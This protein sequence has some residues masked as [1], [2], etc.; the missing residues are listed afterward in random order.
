[1]IGT[2]KV[3][4]IP[5]VDLDQGWGPVLNTNSAFTTDLTDWRAL[6]GAAWVWVTGGYAAPGQVS[7]TLTRAT[8]P[9]A[10]ASMRQPLMR[11]R[12]RVYTPDLAN[13]SIQV[14][15]IY[16]NVP[17]YLA[18]GA[19]YTQVN[20]AQTYPGQGWRVFDTYHDPSAIDPSY[21]YVIPQFFVVNV[22][23]S[24]AN[25]RLDYLE[26]Y[27]RNDTDPVDIT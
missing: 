8:S 11:V 5:F 6:S 10:P 7:S 24:W 2:H 17:N 20:L 9:Q 14:R 25:F 22:G 1:M 21:V 19:R 23:Q 12:A 13:N 27:G 16:C 3:T 4:V 15:L 26:L 18:A